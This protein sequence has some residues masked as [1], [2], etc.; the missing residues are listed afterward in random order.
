[1]QRAKGGETYYELHHILPKSLGGLDL[2]EN[3]VLLTAREHYIAHLLLYAIYKQ[4]GGSAFRKMAFALVS[5]LSN[6]N[7]STYRFSARSYSIMREA[8]M[9][10]S[11]GRKVEDTVN[12]K[13]PKSEKHREAIKQARL[14]APARSEETKNKLRIAA[15]L[16]DKFTANYTKATC[17]HC[18]KEG[19]TTAM[20][21]WHFSNCKVGK[22]VLDA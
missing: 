5:M 22:E 14:A 3:L 6:A 11:L 9:Y 20:R 2:Q 21:R 15:Q 8:A 16:S 1:M 19:Q 7:T 12:Y 13:K 10:A 4:K 17:P 18:L